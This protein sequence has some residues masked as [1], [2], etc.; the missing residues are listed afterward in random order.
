M[1]VILFEVCRVLNI[2]CVHVIFIACI[3][4]LRLDD[5]KRTQQYAFFCKNESNVGHILDDIKLQS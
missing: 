2:V 1:E 3:D 5:L 4:D